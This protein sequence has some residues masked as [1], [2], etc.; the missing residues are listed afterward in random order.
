MPHLVFNLRNVPDDEGIEIRQLLDEH[1][2]DYYETSAGFWGISVAGIWVK[3]DDS[4]QRCKH[5]ISEYQHRRYESVS[6]QYQEEVKR[7]EQRRLSDL[8]LKHPIKFISI[9]I[10]I[11]IILY[12]SIAPYILFI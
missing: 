3:D 6:K 8:L 10:A 12:F 4:A 9:M 11:V 5:L 7:G 2:I 1:H